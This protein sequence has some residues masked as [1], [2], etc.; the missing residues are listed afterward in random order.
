[1]SKGNRTRHFRTLAGH[2]RLW[3]EGAPSDEVM[4]RLRSIAMQLD[5]LASDLEA[6]PTPHALAIAPAESAAG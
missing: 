2:L 5:D 4:E 6:A 1:V 3:A